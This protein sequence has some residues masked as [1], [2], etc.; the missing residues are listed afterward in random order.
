MVSTSLIKNT[1]WRH[2]FQV[3]LAVRLGAWHL[4]DHLID[5]H[6]HHGIGV[7][8]HLELGEHGMEYDLLTAGFHPFAVAVEP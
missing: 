5:V 3:P 7:D 6:A 4:G 8:Q 2:A 1:I